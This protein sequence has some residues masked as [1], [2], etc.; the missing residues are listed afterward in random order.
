MKNTFEINVEDE[1]ARFVSY[2]RD[3]RPNGDEIQ[4]KYCPF[5]EG[6]RRHDQYT[7]AI[8]KNTG[9]FNCMRGSCGR[10]GNLYT[11]SDD[12]GIS[13]KLPEKE[14]RTVRRHVRRIKAEKIAE[15]ELDPK[16]VEFMKGR[17]MSAETAEKYGLT[18]S[19]KAP[20]EG[21]LVIPFYGMGGDLLYVKYRKIDGSEFNGGGKERSISTEGKNDEAKRQ[22]EAKHGKWQGTFFGMKQC[23]FDGSPLVVTEGQMDTMACSEAG[24]QNVVSVPFGKN[25]SNWFEESA[26]AQI[27]L[28]RF[29]EMVVFGDNEGGEVTL[30]EFMR[31]IF[32]GRVRVVR[33]EDYHGQKDANDV[34]KEFGAGAIL[35]AVENAEALKVRRVKEISEI[36]NVNMAEME[37]I[38]TGIT[39]TDKFLGG[40]YFGSLVILSGARGEGKSTFASQLAGFA[41]NQGENV[42]FYSGELTDFQWK[43]W[44]KLQ[45]AGPKGI[46]VQRNP[47]TG[48]DEP[49]I[50]EESSSAI[51]DWYRGKVYVYDNA[52]V[53]DE[54]VSLIQTMEEC[55]QQ[56]GCRFLVV[57]NLMSAMDYSDPNI[58]QNL[59]ETKFVNELRKMSKRFNVIIILVTH[60]RKNRSTVASNDDVSGSGNITNMG[61]LVLQY[62][63]PLDGKG[64]P[65]TAEET[66]DRILSIPKNRLTGKT[67]FSGITMHF[68]SLTK[69]I[70]S[71]GQQKDW[72]FWKDDDEFVSVDDDIQIPFEL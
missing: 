24:I 48:E 58:N 21:C 28:N 42:F 54:F 37:R 66:P 45:I 26:D 5:C 71:D 2:Y 53:D 6:G 60:L 64:K 1:V 4:L 33:V 55:I 46:R 44:F 62:G 52:A 68:D 11:L 63:M 9:A 25:A 12:P 10:T 43:M 14:V 49:I 15:R 38:Q 47:I 27:F 8:N 50:R 56:Y 70:Y 51:E 31:K 30:V 65:L 41:V 23:T 13:Y 35:A 20:Y 57:D 17:G 67:N 18:I 72:C 40:L 29:T 32:S 3:I 19:T 69:R 22:T 34:L 36:R 7:F 61:D 39:A 16:V 59:A